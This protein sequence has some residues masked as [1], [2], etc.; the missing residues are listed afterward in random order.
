MTTLDELKAAWE[1]HDRKLDQSVRLNRE[2]LRREKLNDLRYPLRRLKIGLS[3]EI[4]V[5]VATLIVI[6][7]FLA[8]HLTEARFAWAAGLLDAWLILCVAT[9]IRQL[10]Q[11]NRIEY[12]KPVTTI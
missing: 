10:A 9:S 8:R 7:A 6:G 2:T 12:D 5:A 3:V 1:A 11:A 4:A